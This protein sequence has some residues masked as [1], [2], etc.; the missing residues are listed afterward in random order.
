VTLHHLHL[1]QDK[2]GLIDIRTYLILVLKPFN[3]VDL[4]SEFLRKYIFYIRP[5]SHPPC[6]SGT[7]QVTSL[8][9]VLYICLLQHVL[10]TSP[11]RLYQPSPIFNQTMIFSD[12]LAHLPLLRG[13]G[14][15]VLKRI[16]AC[17][18]ICPCLPADSPA[19]SCK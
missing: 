4:T 3:S 18:L 12:N 17:P 8:Q 6:R 9:N 10:C 7:R 15:R 13:G 2:A 11:A 5:S 16:P 19:T 14:L 1:P